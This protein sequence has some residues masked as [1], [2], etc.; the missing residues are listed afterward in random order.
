MGDIKGT[1]LD[2]IAINPGLLDGD[3]RNIPRLAGS[4]ADRKAIHKTCG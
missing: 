3:A 1:S 4:Q 2:V